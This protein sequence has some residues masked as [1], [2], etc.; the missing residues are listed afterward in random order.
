MRDATTRDET[1]TAGTRF[2]RVLL[3]NLLFSAMVEPLM[4]LLSF[5][6][7]VRFWWSCVT[8]LLLLSL[9]F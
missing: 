1:L 2:L 4:H 6:R 3:S 9:N 8:W 7:P 5:G